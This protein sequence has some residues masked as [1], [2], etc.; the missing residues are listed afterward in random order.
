MF[1]SC[2]MAWCILYGTVHVFSLN[3]TQFGNKH[4]KLAQAVNAMICSIS[5]FSECPLLVYLSL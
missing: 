3:K 4:C 1:M 2:I 5:L